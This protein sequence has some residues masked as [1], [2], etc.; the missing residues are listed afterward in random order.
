MGPRNK[1]KPGM[2]IRP[3]VGI[4]LG[5]GDEPRFW[6]GPSIRILSSIVAKVRTGSGPEAG[7]E[8][9]N[10]S[11]MGIRT[12]SAI[13]AGSEIKIKAGPEVGP[14]PRIRIGLGIETKSKTTK[15]SIHNPKWFSSSRQIV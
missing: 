10:G 12:R 1:A 4:G 6:I 2:G 14:Q 15:A 9:K 3:A 5:I 7:S 8:I 11:E 13:E